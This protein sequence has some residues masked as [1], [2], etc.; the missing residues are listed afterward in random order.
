MLFTNNIID[1]D[2][3]SF[4]VGLAYIS[5]F[6]EYKQAEE[7]GKI[8]VTIFHPDWGLIETYEGAPDLPWL[9]EQATIANFREATSS[10]LGN[11]IKGYSQAAALAMENGGFVLGSGLDMIPEIQASLLNVARNTDATS[12]LSMNDI[13]GDSNIQATLGNTSVYKEWLNEYS[14]LKQGITEHPALFALNN[15]EMIKA[16]NLD[17]DFS[18][19]DENLDKLSLAKL[20]GI[21]EYLDAQIS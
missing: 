3:K 9:Q 2:K 6:E 17:S 12:G 11:D 7:E 5:D 21:K 10:M 20:N 16:Q 19:T 13:Q 1:G 18:L 4:D 14:G 15:Q 8:P